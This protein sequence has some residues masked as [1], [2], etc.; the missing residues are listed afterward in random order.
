V[1]EG[2]R[3][4]SVCRGNPTEGSNPSLSAKL[5]SASFGGAS[6]LQASARLTPRLGSNPSASVTSLSL[7][8]RS[9]TASGIAHLRLRRS[10]RLGSNPSL[11]TFTSARLTR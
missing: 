9:E 11:I 6:G 5:R 4:E 3:L 2:A 7:V 1:V 8:C 10:W